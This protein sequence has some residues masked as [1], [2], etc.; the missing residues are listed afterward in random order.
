METHLDRTTRAEMSALDEAALPHIAELERLRAVAEVVLSEPP[1]AEEMTNVN[2]AAA[3]LRGRI[4]ER[5]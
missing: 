3:E 2:L 5:F 4:K 1:V